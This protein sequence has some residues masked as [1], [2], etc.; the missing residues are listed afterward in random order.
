MKN[1]DTFSFKLGNVVVQWATMLFV[2]SIPSPG[3]F[4]VCRPSLQMTPL[5]PTHRLRTCM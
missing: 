1:E 5:P 2:G 4:C 3:P